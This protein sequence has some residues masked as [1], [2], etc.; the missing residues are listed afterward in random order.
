MLYIVY[1]IFLSMLFIKKLGKKIKIGIICNYTNV[2]IYKCKYRP[3]Y[4][5]LYAMCIG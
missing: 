4:L 2:Y 5:S 3:K 1:N